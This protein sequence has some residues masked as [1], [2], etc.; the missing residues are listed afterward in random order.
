MEASNSVHSASLS[1]S[2]VS[3]EHATGH[4]ITITLKMVYHVVVKSLMQ[5]FALSFVAFVNSIFSKWMH[6]RL[7]SVPVVYMGAL[8]MSNNKNHAETIR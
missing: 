4:C 3:F 8:C 6:I 7:N 1:P 5:I 2:S